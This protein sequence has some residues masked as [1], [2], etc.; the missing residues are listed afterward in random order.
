MRVERIYDANQPGDRHGGR[1]EGQNQGGEE[2]ASGKFFTQ[3]RDRRGQDR[4]GDSGR[5]GG[6]R[7]GARRGGGRA[8]ARRGDARYILLDVLRDGPKHGYEIIKV[9][10]ERSAGQYIPSPGTVYPTL[11]YLEDQGFVRAVQEAERRTYQLTAAGQTELDAQAEQVAAFWKRFAGQEAVTA[12]Q[13]EASFLQDELEHLNRIVWS[14]LRPALAQE[15]QDA[16]RRVRGAVEECQ[17]KV[18]AIIAGEQ[19]A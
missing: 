15:Q 13:H 5:N 19:P 9:L 6:R 3:G 4:R 12:T 18:R 11:Q 8:R 10:E 14:G 16:I 7:G 1:K 17:Q 2:A